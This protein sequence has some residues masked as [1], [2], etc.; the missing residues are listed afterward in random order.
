[1]GK[2]R[3]RQIEICRL[4]R[5]RMGFKDEPYQELQTSK[6]LFEQLFRLKGL[7]IKA[8]EVLDEAVREMQSASDLR[9][10]RDTAFMKK[11]KDSSDDTT[12]A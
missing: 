7:P 5:E 1:M 12:P 8:K 4:E 6:E 10:N 3:Q 9:E 2:E 11:K